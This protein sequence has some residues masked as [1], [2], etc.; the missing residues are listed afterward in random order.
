MALAFSLILN[1]EDE[2]KKK[3]STKLRLPTTFSI[4]QYTEFAVA[5][6]QLYADAS[7]C[8]IT[9]VSLTVDFDFSALGLDGVALIAANVGKKAKFLWET[10]TAGLAAR[11]AVPTVDESIFPADT[12]DMDQSDPIVAPFISAIEN[13][14]A[15][16][17]GT[18]T[19]ANNRAVDILSLNAG[20][21][22]HAKT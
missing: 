22:I 21:E 18:I 1:F 6:A 10:V 14:I 11:F 9:N 4:S 2:T 15:V 3:S 16:T 12:D 8:R 20:Y 19:F 5:A 17:A 13:G 7:Q